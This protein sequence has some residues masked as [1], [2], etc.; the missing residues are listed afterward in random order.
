[1]PS[2]QWFKAKDGSEAKAT[3]YMAW[4]VLILAGV[5]ESV[6]AIALDRSD[7]FSR[8]LPSVVFVVALALSMLGLA[9]ALKTL[10]LGTS[11]AV[12]VGIGVSLTVLYGMV[13]KSEPANPLRIALIVVLVLCV[14]GLKVLDGDSGMVR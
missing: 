14:V 4:T 13:T 10:P 12:W 2:M 7:G 11:Y 8:F 9:H 3:R 1:M 5:F 6:W